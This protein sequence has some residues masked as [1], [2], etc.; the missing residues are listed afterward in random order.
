[1]KRRSFARYRLRARRKEKGWCDQTESS[2]TRKGRR[3]CTYGSRNGELDPDNLLAGRVDV[4]AIDDGK[5]MEVL[6]WKSDRDT[7]LHRAAYVQQLQRYLRATSA[8]LATIVYMT[9]GEIVTVL[10]GA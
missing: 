3:R 4:I 2:G 9:T 8:P 10:P 6:D 5:V 7:K 1:M